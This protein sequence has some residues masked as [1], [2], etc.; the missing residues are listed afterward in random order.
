MDYRFQIV[1]CS[2]VVETELAVY[3]TTAPA[4]I[5]RQYVETL[6]K[7]SPGQTFDV[8]PVGAPFQSMRNDQQFPVAPSQPVKVKKVVIRCIDALAGVGLDPDPTNKRREDRFQVCVEKEQRCFVFHPLVTVILLFRFRRDDLKVAEMMLA[9]PRVSRDHPF[10]TDVLLCFRMHELA[11]HFCGLDPPQQ[12]DK[13]RMQRFQEVNGESRVV[14]NLTGFG[15][16]LFIVRLDRRRFF[17][18]RP[19]D[20]NI[21]VQMAVADM[22]EH[23]ASCPA[24]LAIRSV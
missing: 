17:G 22:V 1:C 6:V 14:G 21:C 13:L 2:A 9:M 5:P 7:S 10:N 16:K 19:F 18:Q 24:T 12:R 11:P 20:A 8:G 15:P 3:L 23:L 4:K